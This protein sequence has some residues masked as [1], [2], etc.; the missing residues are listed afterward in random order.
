MPSQIQLRESY[1]R[2]AILLS[3]AGACVH[4]TV[5][6]PHLKEWRAAGIFFILVTA[7]QFS[8]AVA[9]VRTQREEF[10][11]A[12]IVANVAVIVVY[13]ISR[14]IHLPF[15]PR[16]GAHGMEVIP[17][18]PLVRAQIESIGFIDSLSFLLELG[19][20]VN[21]LSMLGQRARNLVTNGLC[22]CGLALLASSLLG[23][24]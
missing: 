13:V 10:L 5:I 23:V 21:A 8:V 20:I 14:T 1:V 15:A 6:S 11:V 4:A 22:S 2:R 12:A 19:F 7:L 24:L 3:L 18:I 16:V 17:G 9:L